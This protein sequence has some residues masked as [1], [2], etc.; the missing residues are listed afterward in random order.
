MQSNECGVIELPSLRGIS[1]MVVVLDGRSFTFRIPMNQC[2]RVESV[3]V[4]ENTAFS[5]P[6]FSEFHDG[7]K[8]AFKLADS[9]V[10]HCWNDAVQ[11]RDGSF[12]FAKGLAEGSYSLTADCGAFCCDILV[13]SAQN[14]IISLSN[15]SQ[16][17]I[18]Q[19]NETLTMLSESNPLQIASIVG[20]RKRGWKIKLRGNYG[21]HGTRVHV[22]ATSQCPGFSMY[23]SLKNLPCFSPRTTQ[24]HS[25]PTVFCKARAISDE[26][27]YVLERS[28]RRKH[29][30]NLLMPPSLL[31]FP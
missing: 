13:E 19:E 2:A 3:H 21:T 25:A 17:S 11:Y 20:D 23:E 5:I 31:L 16:C 8:V 22:V 1:S 6:F 30:G 14:R 29:C 10:A 18:N 9:T 15:D 12:V 26:Y 28:S 7:D 24:Y 4:A 27:R